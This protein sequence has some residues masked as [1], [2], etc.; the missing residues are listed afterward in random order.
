MRTTID[1]AGRIVIPKA[2]RD[3]AGLAPGAEVEVALYDGRVEIE[4]APIELRLV[5]RDDR[6][7][8]EG[9]EH[10]PP[11]TTEEVRATLERLRDRR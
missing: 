3:Q 8:F 7:A 2:L 9:D 6:V 5:E 1:K 10:L 11:L 4:A